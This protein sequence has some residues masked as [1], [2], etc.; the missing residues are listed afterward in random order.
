M[1]IMKKFFAFFSL[2]LLVYTGFAFTVITTIN[3]Y[4]LII[5]DIVGDKAKVSVLIN[6]GV[7][8]HAF[9][10]RV[11]D[12]KTLMSAD[13]IVMNGL[14]LE[15]FLIEKLKSINLKNSVLYA[16]D[17]I[18]REILKISNPDKEHVNPHVW[19]SIEFLT[20]YII[21]GIVGRLSEL[22]T[23]N[24]EYF[25]K[26]SIHLISELEKL[27][28]KYEE[29]FKDYS[30]KTVLVYHPSFYYFFNELGIKIISVSHGHGDEPTLKELMEIIKRVKSG[31]IVA[32]FGEKQQNIEPVKI[33]SSQTGIYFEVLDPLGY[34]SKNT[35]ELFERNFE[36][37]LEGFEKY[38]E[39]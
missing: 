28:K 25:K 14:S 18:P 23:K 37:V 5:K 39:K 34:D 6:P 38:G 8:P 36:T 10:P 29:I 26:N 16:S 27:K 12:I 13:L 20:K 2:I 24:A 3:P 15:E 11:S 35:V 33:I 1:M 21:P 22:D 31:E 32:I 9:S 17:T 19:L 7:N 30:G 4:G